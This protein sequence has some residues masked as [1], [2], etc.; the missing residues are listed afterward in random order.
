VG[1]SEI[2][3]D[4]LNRAAL[5]QWLALNPRVA[6]DLTLKTAELVDR[7]IETISQD[8]FVW[9]VTNPHVPINIERSKHR[10]E[11]IDQIQHTIK[12]GLG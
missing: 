8:I 6:A 4:A 3:V 7:K 12:S 11:H 5:P 2:D 9:C 10:A 1:A